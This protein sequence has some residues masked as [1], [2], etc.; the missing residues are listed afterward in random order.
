MKQK[1]AWPQNSRQLKSL[2]IIRFVFLKEGGPF[3][4]LRDF[5]KAK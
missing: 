1:I 4:A 5:V 2:L 3:L